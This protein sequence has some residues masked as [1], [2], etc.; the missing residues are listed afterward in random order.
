MGSFVEVL[1]LVVGY[2]VIMRYVMPKVGIQT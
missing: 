1:L 2:V